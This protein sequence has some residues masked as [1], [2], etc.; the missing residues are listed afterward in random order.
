MAENHIYINQ[1]LT[2]TLDT[3]TSLSAVSDAKIRYVDPSGNIATKAASVSSQ[4]LVA[5]FTG[6]E[7]DEIGFWEW[8]SWVI[9]TGDTLPT[10]GEPYK[11]LVEEL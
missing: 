6:A 10:P 1:P 2:V 11:H 4:S 9:F 3:K 8:R 7:I 5:S